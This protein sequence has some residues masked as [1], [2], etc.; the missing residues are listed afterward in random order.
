MGCRNARGLALVSAC[1]LLVGANAG[2]DDVGGESIVVSSGDGDAAQADRDS[3]YAAIPSNDHIRWVDGGQWRYGTYY[4]F[5]LTRNMDESGLARGWQWA[6]YP[7]AVGIDVV[8]LPAGLFGGL[9][10]D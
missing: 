8:Q 7:L 6:L 4:L 5:P 3:A 2:A 9:Y 10:G 1:L